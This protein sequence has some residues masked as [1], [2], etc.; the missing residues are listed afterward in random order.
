[1]DKEKPV[2]PP[3]T[4]LLTEQTSTPSLYTPGPAGQRKRGR[5]TFT[6]IPPFCLFT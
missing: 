3:T 2:C 1:M 5:T 4:N 6:S